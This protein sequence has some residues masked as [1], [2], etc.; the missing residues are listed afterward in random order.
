MGKIS[1]HLRSNVV[2]SVALFVVLS[3]TAYVLDG[4]LPGPNTVGS[5]DII[6]N[7]VYSVD[8]S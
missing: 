2:G 8:A 4:P 5:A 1:D 7:E 3:G 6:N